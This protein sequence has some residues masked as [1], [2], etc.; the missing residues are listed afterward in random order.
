MDLPVEGLCLHILKPHIL[1][2]KRLRVRVVSRDRKDFPHPERVP[3]PDCDGRHSQRLFQHLN[4]A[5][6][7]HVGCR[8]HVPDLIR[9]EL[10]GHESLDV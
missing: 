6:K 4:F 9:L 1:P 5:V 7:L 8:L 2:Q 3:S 10:Q